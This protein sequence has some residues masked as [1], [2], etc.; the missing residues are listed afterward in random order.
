MGRSLKHGPLAWRTRMRSRSLI[1]ALLDGAANGHRVEW[2]WVE[3]GAQL[4]RR[5][6]VIEGISNG[7]HYF[8][9]RHLESC[10]SRIQ[11]APHS[12]LANL[13]AFDALTNAACQFGLAAGQIHSSLE[14]FFAHVE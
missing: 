11:P 10:R 13:R 14:G 8:R 6:A 1:L 5:D 2:V 12:H 9:R 3:V 4:V 7:K